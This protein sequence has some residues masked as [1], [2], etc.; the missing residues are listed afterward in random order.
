MNWLKEKNSSIPEVFP[1]K[2]HF[3]DFRITKFLLEKAT[4]DLLNKLL[5]V[6]I[7]V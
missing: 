4:E 7:F 2:K 5:D 1:A 3:S 6:R